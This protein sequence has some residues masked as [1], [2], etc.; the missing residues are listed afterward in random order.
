MDINPNKAYWITFNVSP[1]DIRRSHMNGRPWPSSL[2]PGVHRRLVTGTEVIM[3]GL[4]DLVDG[5]LE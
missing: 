3:Y 5:P 1:D 4:R 2:V